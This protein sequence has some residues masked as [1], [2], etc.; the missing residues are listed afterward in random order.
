MSPLFPQLDEPSLV[1]RRPLMRG[2]RKQMRARSRLI[3][4][5]TPTLLAVAAG[6]CGG[7]EDSHMVDGRRVLIDRTMV[8]RIRPPPT[9]R[10]RAVAQHDA[11]IEPRP[12]PHG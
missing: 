2:I 5:G 6:A 3:S 9:P 10:R 4:A 7:G 12:A 1:H 11:L 8:T